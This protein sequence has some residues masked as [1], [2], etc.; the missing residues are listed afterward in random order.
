MTSPVDRLMAKVEVTSD[1]C[2]AWT[3]ARSGKGWDRGGGYAAFYLDGRLTSGHR[4]AYELFVGPIP[5]GH[6]IDHLCH[7]PATCSE[8]PCPHR[9]CVNPDHLRAVTAA[10]NNARS[11][12]PSALRARVTHCPKGHPYDEANTYVSP[13][14]GRGCR[15]CRCASVQK[16]KA[17]RRAST[18]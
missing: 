13:K 9:Q 16:A 12:S 7:D 17:K 3:G 4:A 8:D 6:Q 1:G 15:I 10:A 5:D 11:S 2:W 14:G 18:P